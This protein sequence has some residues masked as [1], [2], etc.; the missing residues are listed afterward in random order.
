MS[1]SRSPTLMELA[2]ANDCVRWMLEN[3]YALSV[4][5]VHALVVK[6]DRR[7]DGLEA[8]A[9]AMDQGFKK[10]IFDA[11]EKF[12]QLEKKVDRLEE[13]LRAVRKGEGGAS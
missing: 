3:N 5:G 2:Q 13:E 6:L 4:A 7:L 9:V 1:E 8:K 10:R 12:L 11:G